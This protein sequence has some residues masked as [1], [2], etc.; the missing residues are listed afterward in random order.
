[1]VPLLQ[2]LRLKELAVTVQ[3]CQPRRKLQ[4]RSPSIAASS[5]SRLV[6]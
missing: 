2:S 5:L 4:P 6:M 1:M 3:L